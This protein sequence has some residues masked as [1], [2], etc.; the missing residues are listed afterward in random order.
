MPKL[1][2]DQLG[3][4]LRETFTDHVDDLKSLPEATK[5][6]RIAPALVAAAAVLT[7]LAGTVMNGS[8]NTAQPP[9]PAASPPFAAAASPDED[10][11][12]WSTVASMVIQ[13]KAP[14]RAFALAAVGVKMSEAQRNDVAEAVG[15][16]N[17]V[18]WVQLQATSSPPRKDTRYESC[19]KL[20][21]PIVFV[22]EVV[23]KGRDREIRAGVSEGCGYAESALYRLEKQGN[24][25]MIESVSGVTQT[26]P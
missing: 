2:D 5:R 24:T 8:L 16:G 26:I 23:D 15:Q 9:A 18:S 11:Q 4:L 10:T 25:W 3:D 20:D 13:V 6:R 17:K 21:I 1:T 22:G 19:L 12:I 14:Q 7:V